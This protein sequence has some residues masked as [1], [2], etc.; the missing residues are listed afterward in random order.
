MDK[1]RGYKY[2]GVGKGLVGLGVI[3]MAQFG[4]CP[5]CGELTLL[6]SIRRDVFGNLVAFVKCVNCDYEDKKK[7]AYSFD[8]CEDDDYEDDDD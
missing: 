6:A 7:L 4:R 1:R 5:E 8:L 3:E 2:S